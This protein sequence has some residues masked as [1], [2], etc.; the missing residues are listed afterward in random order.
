MDS[1]S[2]HS[3]IL[4]LILTV[5]PMDQPVPTGLGVMESLRIAPKPN[6]TV[7]A[8][9]VNYQWD[10]AY[11]WGRTPE[12]GDFMWDAV[13]EF[14]LSHAKN[15]HQCDS[16]VWVAR[17]CIGHKLILGLQALESSLRILV[18]SKEEG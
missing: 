5:V 11:I 3:T 7:T 14:F 2:H 9:V 8:D 17:R 6:T 16:G 12:H 13:W 4:H 15:Q 10:G 1:G 18:E